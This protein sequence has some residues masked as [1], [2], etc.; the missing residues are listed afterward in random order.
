MPSEAGP[1]VCI[2]Q[3]RM[4]STRLPGKVLMEAAGKPLLAHHLDRLG[5][6]RAIDR[7]V[8]ATTTNATD[9]PI[10]AFCAARG[11]AVARGSEDDVLGRFA[12]AAQ[13]AGAG[14]VVRATSDCPLID[15]GVVAGQIGMW[16]A[17]GD[18]RACVTIDVQGLPRGIG[19]EVFSHA[20][21]R[22]AAA[23]AGPDERE[24]VTTYFYR[25][26][27]RFRTVVWT[28]GP[29]ERRE[30]SRWCVD[31]PADLELVRVM[32]ETLRRERPDFGWRDV[33]DLTRRHPEWA[34]INRH[35]RQKT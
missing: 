33:V 28:T 3:A 9:D 27:E 23:Q 32:L 7:L 10:A 1:V 18:P 14:V 24:H 34:A 17:L 13:A 22:E 6:C 29:D 21:L 2:T 4:T 11:V 30:P 26:P 16:L 8:V 25:R 35:V 19:V 5:A 12:Q 20:A 15:P 31:E